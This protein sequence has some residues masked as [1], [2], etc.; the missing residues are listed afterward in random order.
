M[1]LS[2]T[3]T[4]TRGRPSVACRRDSRGTG[5]IGR[6]TVSEILLSLLAEA[7]GTALVG[8]VLIAIR[9]AIGAARA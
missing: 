1:G 3:D 5:R 6:N 7:L 2:F 4:T 8:L 9:R